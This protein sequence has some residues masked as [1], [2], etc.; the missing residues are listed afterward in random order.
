MPN[1]ERALRKPGWCVFICIR[2]RAGERLESQ[3][4]E[5]EPTKFWMVIGSV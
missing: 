3:V 2:Q 4:A 5:M 1:V